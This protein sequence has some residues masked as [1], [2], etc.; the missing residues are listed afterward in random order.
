MPRTWGV[1]ASSEPVVNSGMVAPFGYR[2]DNWSLTGGIA[3]VD[4]A[5]DT[6]EVIVT[7]PGSLTANFSSLLPLWAPALG[8]GTIF[9][10]LIPLAGVI[11]DLKL[12]QRRPPRH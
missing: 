9:L 11:C 5:L 10:A 3:V 4:P 2:F 6:A 1:V 7:G 12:R 8:L